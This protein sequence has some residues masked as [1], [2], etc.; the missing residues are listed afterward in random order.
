MVIDTRNICQLQ[1]PLCPTGVG[2][3]TKEKNFME[4]DGFKKNC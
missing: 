2:W 3:P 1:C 4:F